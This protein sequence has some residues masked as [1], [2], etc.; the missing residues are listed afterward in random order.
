MPHLVLYG[1]FAWHLC[2]SNGHNL[3]ARRMVFLMRQCRDLQPR[4]R[5]RI[6][7][8]LLAKW[9]IEEILEAAANYHRDVHYEDRL[10]A[11]VGSVFWD[12]SPAVN[13]VVEKLRQE[14]TH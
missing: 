13:A 12:R 2:S 7:D 11:L 1:V 4:N 9:T 10:H 8:E 6:F 5:Q 14:E 3:D